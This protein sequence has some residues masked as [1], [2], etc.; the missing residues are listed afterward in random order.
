MEHD[1]F[2]KTYD[3]VLDKNLIKNIMDSSRD[4]DWE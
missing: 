4:V 2:I 1:H 3:D